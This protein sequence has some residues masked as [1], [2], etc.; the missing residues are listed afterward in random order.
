MMNTAFY[1]W[2]KKRFPNGTK[3]FSVRA[4]DAAERIES[5][6]NGIR[7]PD[8]VL[9][10][11]GLIGGETPIRRNEF[12]L[13]DYLHGT[14]EVSRAEDRAQIGILHRYRERELCGTA[15]SAHL[16]SIHSF[17]VPIAAKQGDQRGKIDLLGTADKELPAV[18]ELK[19]LD[20][21]G[22]RSVGD[23][24]GPIIQGLAYALTIR[25]Y[26]ACSDGFQL[27]W[28]AA[29]P[30]FRLPDRLEDMPSPII[31]AADRS[32]WESSAEWN[33]CP[34]SRFEQLAQALED[35]GL[36]LFAA[37]FESPDE[38]EPELEF[39]PFTKLEGD[40]KGTKP[41]RRWP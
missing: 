4:A 26:L 28:A 8:F 12:K 34:W 9:N 25:Y 13:R 16:K 32:F 20:G 39:I 40:N 33:W 1:E 23:L 11:T 18:I 7:N 30:G 27:E 35:A 37:R 3:G 17:Q 22:S 21:K 36:P 41:L 29:N 31:V 5:L 2:T 14:H 15:K 38:P 24:L 19:C 6:T 10:S